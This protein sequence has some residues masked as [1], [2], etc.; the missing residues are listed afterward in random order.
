MKLI[1]L[2]TQLILPL[3]LLIS[4]SAQSVN[5]DFIDILP[6]PE[7]IF[8]T[9]MKDVN[10]TNTAMSDEY[11]KN[12]DVLCATDPYPKSLCVIPPKIKRLKKL[13]K[14][15]FRS[16]GDILYPEDM[17]RKNIWDIRELTSANFKLIPSLEGPEATLKVVVEIFVLRNEILRALAVTQAQI[18]KQY[19]YP[20]ENMLLTIP[21][22]RA[23]LYSASPLGAALTIFNSMRCSSKEVLCDKL[24][25]R[26]G[27]V[28]EVLIQGNRDRI[29]NFQKRL[30]MASNDE[31]SEHGRRLRQ[32]TEFAEKMQ[33]DQLVLKTEDVMSDIDNLV[34]DGKSAHADVVYQDLARQL[35]VLAEANLVSKMAVNFSVYK[36]EINKSDKQRIK[37]QLLP[38]V[39]ESLDAINLGFVTL[40]LNKEM[41]D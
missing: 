32:I 38:L 9:V 40:G 35:I 27:A 15:V 18:K 29:L 6:K 19:Q 7:L 34:G 25:S 8:L 3:I 22:I 14:K 2:A 12:L 30:K 24:K 4:N 36:E 13:M 21:F 10:G 37:T 41:G 5:Q 16:T 39:N 1:H 33:N 17:S 31:A 23:S 28:I 11:W 26:Q 20:S